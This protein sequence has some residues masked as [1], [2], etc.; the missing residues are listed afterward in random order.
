MFRVLGKTALVVFILWHMFAIGVYSIPRSANDPLSTW[1][2]ATF[3]RPVAPYLFWTSQW[4]Q[5]N[6]FSPDPLRRVTF[7]TI[8][9]QKNGRWETIE[10]IA[11]DSLSL[12]RRATMMKMMGNLFDQDTNGREPFGGKLLELMCTKY[13]VPPNTPIRMQYEWYV[14]PAHPTLQPSAWWLQW[15]P[16]VQH[17]TAFESRCTTP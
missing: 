12:W 1:M 13:E 7:Y 8:D 4:Q 14:I 15:N 5:W 3:V 10:R 6:M 9:I 16:L 17:E 2:L 11:P